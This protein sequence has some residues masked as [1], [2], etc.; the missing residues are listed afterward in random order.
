MFPCLKVFCILNKSRI[1]YAG[2][3]A[4]S[5]NH[6]PLHCITIYDWLFERTMYYHDEFIPTYWFSSFQ[7]DTK[8][9]NYEISLGYS[10]S[11]KTPAYKKERNNRFDTL[12]WNFSTPE[13]YTHYTIHVSDQ[14][15][16][17][18]D[19]KEFLLHY[20]SNKIHFVPFLFILIIIYL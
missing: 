12:F 10:Y 15:Y 5:C 17:Y 13:G 16:C 20:F 4:N 14:L 19:E 1:M 8:C 11:I 9:I 18:S 2:F 3:L 6:T 7:L